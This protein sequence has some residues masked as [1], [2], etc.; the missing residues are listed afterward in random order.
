MI[1]NGDAKPSNLKKT[2]EIKIPLLED[3][4]GISQHKHVA[5]GNGEIHKIGNGSAADGCKSNATRN[6]IVTSKVLG[7][8]KVHNGSN[9][10]LP[11]ESDL[12]RKHAEQK[13]CNLPD[14]VGRWYCCNDSY[15]SVSNLQ[16]VLSEK[17]YI[18]FFSRTKHRHV[19]PNKSFATNGTKA[20]DSNGSDIS[21]IPKSGHDVESTNP[22]QFVDHHSQKAN[23]AMSS[24]VDKVIFNVQRKPGISGNENNDNNGDAKPSNLKKT[25]EIKIPLLEDKNGIS[26]HKHVANGNGEI[27]KIGNGSAADGCKSNA[28]RNGIVTSKVLGYQKV[29]NGS[30]KS[31]PI[32]SDLKRKHAEQKS[33][34]LPVDDHHSLAN[35]KELKE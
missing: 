23:S 6:G 28:T 14:A 31:L 20:C 15:V 8:Q 5:N 30:N 35:R 10:S 4:N 24:K 21:K 19:L 2:S 11:I 13:S 16:E 9:K 33:C 7:Y 3:K 17:V 29:H 18:L 26:Q 32:E 1:Y 34:N 22:Q 27:H 12:K 25:S